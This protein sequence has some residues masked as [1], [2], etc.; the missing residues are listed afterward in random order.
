MTQPWSGYKQSGFGR[1]KC[2][3]TLLA[4]TQTKSV[5]VHLDG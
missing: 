4:H 3:E 2:F 5:W 1:D